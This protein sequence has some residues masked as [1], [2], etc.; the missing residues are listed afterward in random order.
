MLPYERAEGVKRRTHLPAIL[1]GPQIQVIIIGKNRVK[2][3]LH[4]QHPL[5]LL[6]IFQS[7]GVWTVKIMSAKV[8]FFDFII[9]W[10]ACK[11]VFC[12]QS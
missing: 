8:T 10:Q 12:Q 6:L 2:M 4:G 9:L 5:S 3:I 11:D 7:Q 1:I